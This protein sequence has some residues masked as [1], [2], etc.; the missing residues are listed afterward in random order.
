MVPIRYE[1]IYTYTQE[2]EKRERWTTTLSVSVSVF[3]LCL[4]HSQHHLGC[5]RP[6][7]L[8]PLAWW[9]SFRHN[10]IEDGSDGDCES[11]APGDGDDDRFAKTNLHDCG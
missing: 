5:Q 9:S 8:V 11:V 1:R 7:N 10:E 4:H 2:E 6:E 3:Q